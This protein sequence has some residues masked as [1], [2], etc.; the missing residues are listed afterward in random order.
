MTNKKIKKN[1][2]HSKLNERCNKI[3]I[4]KQTIKQSISKGIEQGSLI[5][6]VIFSFI[7][8]FRNMGVSKKKFDQSRYSIDDTLENY[9]QS[10][11]T[12]LRIIVRR[13]RSAFVLS[14]REL[15]HKRINSF[16]AKDAAY[17]GCLY[18]AEADHKDP[19]L[20]VRRE[21]KAL[22]T[23]SVVC[24]GMLFISCLVLSNL[25]AFKIAEIH[26][27]RYFNAS[28]IFPSALIFFPLTYL[29]NNIITEVY[30]FKVARLI[31][32]GGLI[33]NALLMIGLELTVLL[34]PTASWSLQEA[35]SIIYH[36]SFRI[37][38]ASTAGYFIGEFTNSMILAKLKLL[39]EG[40]QLWLRVVTSTFIGVGIDSVIFCTIAFFGVIPNEMIRH[41][42]VTQYIFKMAIEIAAL[43]LTYRVVKYLKKKDDIDSYDDKTNFNPFSLKL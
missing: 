17:I 8:H 15:Y 29:F 31:I 12:Y 38:L 39:T 34:P 5:A 30:S 19:V 28:V 1:D 9:H 20:C 7:G 13:N 11:K 40:K 2:A 32:W 4:V 18:S 24:I 42:I 6:A 21:G 43:P 41:L 16:L 10:G 27:S 35:Y 33:C 36:S 37:F 14:V 23:K 26:F 22:I 25:T 3:N